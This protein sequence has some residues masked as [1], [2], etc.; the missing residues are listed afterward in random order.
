MMLFQKPKEI[1]KTVGL[2]VEEFTKT[3]QRNTTEG[4][5]M[6]FGALQQMGDKDALAALS[7]L[8]KDLSMDGV[9]MSTVL[10]TMADKLDM[11]KEQMVVANEAFNEGI[12]CEREY[13][14]F[15]NT[16][17]ASIEQAKKRFH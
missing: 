2:D 5:M 12:S 9:R 11:V 1:A 15:N 3:L 4:L 7:P 8:F 13:S 16:V 14:I 17:Q 10:A 6:F